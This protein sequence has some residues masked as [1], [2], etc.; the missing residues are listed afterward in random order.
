MADKK[1]F[2]WKKKGWIRD[3][4]CWGSR[5]MSQLKQIITVFVVAFCISWKGK[6]IGN[7]RIFYIMVTSNKYEVTLCKLIWSYGYVVF[8]YIFFLQYKTTFDI[9]VWCLCLAFTF[10][11]LHSVFVI[12]ISTI[13]CIFHLY[14]MFVSIGEISDQDY[15]S[16]RQQIEDI[17][18]SL[19]Q[20][21]F[22]KSTTGYCKTA[23]SGSIVIGP[24]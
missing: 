23:Q 24:T 3:I 4:I 5:Y 2:L 1:E 19:L 7:F 22:R 20:S 14:L 12:C 21:T 13:T 11:H 6:S 15:K 9:F 18:Q 8:F 16:Y 17:T 10:Q